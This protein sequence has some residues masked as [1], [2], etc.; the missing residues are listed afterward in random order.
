MKTRLRN[1][2]SAQLALALVLALVAMLS[3]VALSGCGAGETKAVT[4]APADNTT[5]VLVKTAANE[6]SL[7]DWDVSAADSP[8]TISSDDPL[9]TDFIADLQQIT[10]YDIQS[11]TMDVSITTTQGAEIAATH[12]TTSENQYTILSLEAVVG[13]QSISYADGDF[14]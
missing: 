7:V 12:E 8:L 10:G 6:L 11:L 3:L 5:K 4:A 9:Y 14:R 13:S 2:L 1:A